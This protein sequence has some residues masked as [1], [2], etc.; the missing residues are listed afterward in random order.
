MCLNAPSKND[1]KIKINKN[2]PL[3]STL[4]TVSDLHGCIII[5]MY[6]NTV[7]LKLFS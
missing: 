1:T 4:S 3:V 6:Y 2:I 5:T 7:Y